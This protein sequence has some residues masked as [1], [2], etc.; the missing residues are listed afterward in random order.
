L[1]Y[2]GV[3][4]LRISRVRGVSETTTFIITE[5]LVW[6][7]GFYYFFNKLDK[8]KLKQYVH[9]LVDCYI[10]SIKA[11]RKAEGTNAENLLATL[12]LSS[13]DFNENVKS[14]VRNSLDLDAGKPGSITEKDLPAWW[15]DFKIPKLVNTDRTKTSHLQTLNVATRFFNPKSQSNSQSDSEATLVSPVEYAGPDFVFPGVVIG[16]KTTK[17]LANNYRVQSE[18]SIKNAIQIRPQRFYN[19]GDRIYQQLKMFFSLFHLGKKAL[20]DLIFSF[21]SILIMINF[22]FVSLMSKICLMMTPH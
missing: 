2:A 14:L 4:G 22:V 17:V 11:E 21:L 13:G 18:A 5:P 1:T 12:L 6:T 7:S 15:E 20:F 16:L 3:A 9:K 10:E 8:E 19:T